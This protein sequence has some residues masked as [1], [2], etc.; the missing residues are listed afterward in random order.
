MNA[1]DL[2]WQRQALVFDLDGT[3]VHTLPDLTDALNQALAG[4]GLGRV[5]EDL[6]RGSL[7]GGL[8]GSVDAAI[9]HLGLAPALRPRLVDRYAVCY[10]Q[11][12]AVRSAPYPGVRSIL[13]RL[14]GRGVRLAVCTNKLEA[15][16]VRL[17][18]ALELLGS[19]ELV[20]GA[21]TCAERKPSPVPLLHAIAGLQA[22][23][24]E[25]LLIG[26][27]AV[28]AACAF[29]AEVSCLLFTGGY[30]FRGLGTSPGVLPFA[31]W[32]SL[33]RSEPSDVGEV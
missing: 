26:D 6:V 9:D 10:E 32:G 5:S 30:G 7:H 18:E 15:Q 20:V 27:S 1:A 21:D 17:L 11:A 25:A 12:L 23:T 4:E 14:C 24:H 33:L 13:D 2:F 19:F 31:S 16:A 8:E 28:D 22:E 3:L 29:G